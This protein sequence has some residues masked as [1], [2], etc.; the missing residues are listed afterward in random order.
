MLQYN[1]FVNQAFSEPKFVLKPEF[2]TVS[3]IVSEAGE[4]P[5]GVWFRLFF[6]SPTQKIY[7]KVYGSP[8]AIAAV[9]MLARK[10]AEKDLQLG[11]TLDLE[12]FRESLDMPYPYMNILLTLEDAW[13]QLGEQI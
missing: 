5:R 13:N 6:E 7:Y 1:D 9:E 2:D 4:R 11:T 10:V 8:Y 3:S 12:V